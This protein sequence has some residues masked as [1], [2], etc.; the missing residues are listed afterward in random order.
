MSRSRR[1]HWVVVLLLGMSSVQPGFAKAPEVDE[2]PPNPLELK[3]P[4]PLLPN[5]GTNRPLSETER[6]QLSGALDALNAQAA[7]QLQ[8]G[9]RVKAFETWNRELRLRR[10]LGLLP[11]VQALGRV[12]ET[13]WNENDTPQVRWITKRLDAIQAQMQTPTGSTNATNQID[14]LDALA[15]AY[16]RVRL[17][18]AASRVYQQVLTDA[19]QRKDAQKTE[20]TLTTLGQL[21]LDWFDYPNAAATYE[22]LLSGAKARG[23]RTNQALFLNQLAF[24][25]EQ[26]KQ[27]QPALNYQQQLVDLYQQL[28]TPAP[29]P[30]LKIKIADNYTRLSQSAQAE[31]NY[32]SAYQLAQPL[33]QF[34]YASDALQK[35]GTLY[36]TNDRLDAALRVYDFLVVVEQQA[37]NLYGMM[38][39]YDQIG[40]IQ[41]A[42]NAYPQALVAFQQGLVL[43]RQLKYREDYFTS[44]IQQV[45]QRPQQTP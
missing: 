1:L 23:D 35:L 3:T 33:S 39:A 21:Y 15:F 44:Q 18:A 31:E 27:P 42:R 45:T 40:Q 12:G 25:H 43:A 41:I 14:V 16:Q 34:G 19:R 30:A 6:K 24:L 37:Y 10:S 13:A 2:F 9:D 7:Q 28:N 17:P 22:E 8:S 38:N 36:R 20:A 11:E 32:Q 4:D 26:A 29:I 5:T